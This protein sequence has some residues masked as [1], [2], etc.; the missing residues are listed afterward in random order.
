[1]Q[2]IQSV[3]LQLLKEIDELCSKN[4]IS[5]CLSGITAESAFTKGIIEDYDTEII[6]LM[7][8]PN[9]KKFIEAAENGLLPNR[10]VESMLNNPYFPNF[11][12]HYTATDTLYYPLS[13]TSRYRIK[14]KGIHIRI[15]IIHSFSKNKF[16][17]A[18]DD[19]LQIGWRCNQSPF[20]GTRSIKRFISM[21]ATRCMMVIG[22]QNL[23]RH[24]F[25]KWCN[26]FSTDADSVRGYYIRPKI[27]NILIDDYVIKGNF[28]QVEANGV[29][30][31]APKNILTY[32]KHEIS[33]IKWPNYDPDENRSIQENLLYSTIITYDEL[34]N[35]LSNENNKLD[36]LY[37]LRRR[38]QFHGLMVVRDNR[39]KNYAWNVA[40]RSGDR[41]NLLEFYAP[42]FSY[43]QYLYDDRDIDRLREELKPLTDA[44]L[45]YYKKHLGLCVHPFLTELQNKLFIM[46]GMENVVEDIDKMIPEQHRKPIVPLEY[47]LDKL[48]D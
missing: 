10:A 30:F 33:G 31:P 21:V 29:K 12:L 44:T 14:N 47:M 1:M 46:D 48:N 17:K 25:N 2:D 39:Y 23:A 42:K 36:N 20:M 22:R 7:T 38:V 9:A 8:P 28:R 16:K 40:S 18:Y 4:E 37:R 6:I 24:L 11:R 43:L 35:R 41:I 19:M 32:A 45:F 3:L 13:N 5:Y 26:E 34:S 27:R 15:E